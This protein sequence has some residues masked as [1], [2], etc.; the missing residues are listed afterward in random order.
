MTPAPAVELTPSTVVEY[1]ASR[2]VRPLRV[3]ELP[4]GVSNTVLLVETETGR[5][6]LK[7]S[8]PQLRVEQPWLSDR[9]RIWREADALEVL[10]PYLPEAAV[11]SVLFRDDENYL[12]AMTAAPAGIETWKSALLRGECDP[13]VA[14][15]VGSITAALM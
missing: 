4:G 6:V 3:S 15:R 10:A 12:F 1:L 13:G 2:G 9:S 8:L 11:P 5:F 14:S 7:Q